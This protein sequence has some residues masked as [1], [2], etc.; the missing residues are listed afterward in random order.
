MDAV[1]FQLGQ[2]LEQAKQTNRGR[3]PMSGDDWEGAQDALRGKEMFR[4]FLVVVVTRCSPSPN[5][6]NSTLHAGAFYW[7][8]TVFQEGLGES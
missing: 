7:V 8:H 4:A 1:R 2:V 6:S 5:S 3:Q